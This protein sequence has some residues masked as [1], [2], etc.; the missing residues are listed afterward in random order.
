MRRR[1]SRTSMGSYWPL[2][3]QVHRQFLQS[4]NFD[5]LRVIPTAVALDFVPDNFCGV[6]NAIDFTP[7]TEDMPIGAPIDTHE[8]P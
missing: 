5:D 6:R 8:P 2:S 7:I 3:L 1:L 4:F